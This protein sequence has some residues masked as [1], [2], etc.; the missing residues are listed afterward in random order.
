MR[1]IGGKDYY[2]HGL[3]LGHDPKDPVVLVRDKNPNNFLDPQTYKQFPFLEEL[4][5]R[6]SL[7]IRRWSSYVSFRIG[8]K[9]FHIDGIKVFFCGKFYQGM[10]VNFKDHKDDYNHLKPFKVVWSPEEFY[11]LLERKTDSSITNW[12]YGEY[13]HMINGMKYSPIPVM[14]RVH[15]SIN[16]FFVTSNPS[17]NFM[18]FVREHRLSFITYR[19]AYNQYGIL[20]NKNWYLNHDDLGTIEFFKVFDAY[21]AFQELSMWVGNMPTMGHDMYQLSDKELITK[22]GFDKW[23]FRKTP[24]K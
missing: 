13:S 23:S 17:E 21:Q 6:N 18:T 8:D 22:H 10:I 14:D 15:E 11:S 16:Q 20:N 2:D 3:G 9:E 24:S 4:M 19:P 7:Q 5:G 12:D 1:I